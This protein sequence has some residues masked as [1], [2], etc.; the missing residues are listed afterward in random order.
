MSD[1]RFE[2]SEE[3]A[4]YLTAQDADDL[5][6]LSALCQDAVFP[7]TEMI[8]KS[9][10]RQFA[11]LLNR[12]RWED[13]E[14]AERE[15]RGFERVRAVLSV[16]DVTKVSSLGIDQSDT[17]IILSVLSISFEA[18]ADGTGR[19]VITLAGDGAV[20]L[21]VECLD[22]T[23]RDVSQPYL[24]PSGKAPAHAL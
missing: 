1:A 7:I 24:A 3:S 23:L 2:D 18:G 13:R 9:R 12:F 5:I 22:L 15:G 20:S 11:I 21:E 10:Q 4:L 6:V 19:L 14:A 17:D 16:A 8:W